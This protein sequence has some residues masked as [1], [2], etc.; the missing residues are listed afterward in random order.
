VKR[1]PDISAILR[2]N[3]ACS[4]A[5]AFQASVAELTPSAQWRACRRGGWLLWYCARVGVDHK[6]LVRAAC[7]CARLALR[8]VPAGEP[9]PLAAIETAERWCDGAA[10]LAEVRAAAHAAYAAAYNAAAYA[11]AV[12]A[13]AAADAYAYAYAYVAAARARMQAR[14]A[15][16]VRRVIPYAVVLEA[17]RKAEASL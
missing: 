15:A 13:Y 12:A 5:S 4:E 6:L 3:Y 8:Y 10:T 16:A 14:C 1:F 2:R 17:T 7:A 9:R 11:A